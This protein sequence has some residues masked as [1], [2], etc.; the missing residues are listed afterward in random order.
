MGNSLLK[1][2]YQNRSDLL[3]AVQI[4]LDEGHDPSAVTEYSESPLRVASNN[5]RFDVVKLLLSKGADESQLGWTNIFHAIAYGSL[6]NLEEAI[7]GGSDLDARDFWSRTPFLF[8]ILVGDIRKT[9]MLVQAGADTSAVGR[10]GKTPMAYAIKKDN[11]DMLNWLI[12]RGFDIEQVNDFGNAPLMEAVKAGAVEC[13]KA[14][15]NKG[16][17]ISKPNSIPYMPIHEACNLEIVHALLEAGADINDMSK[18]SR[19]EMLGYCVDEAP[20]TSEEEYFKGKHRVFGKSNP[21][22]SKNAFWYAMVK[23]GGSAYHAISKFEKDRNT[24]I[25]EPTLD[26]RNLRQTISSD[27]RSRFMVFKDFKV[28]RVEP[29]WSYDRFGKSITPLKD[30]RFIEI[31]GEHEDSYDPDFCIYND[32]FVHKGNGECEIYTYPR[33][34][35]PPTDFHTAT[36]VGEHIYII[37]NL[38]YGEDRQSGYTPIYQLDINT[39]KM[40]KIDTSGDMPG[41]INRHKAYYDGKSAIS[42]KGGNLI[43]VENGKEDY[44]DNEQEY[45]LCLKSLVWNKK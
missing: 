18:E 5:G 41:W 15:I 20:D 38:G 6:E 22:L 42:I 39:L 37:G 1:T 28:C 44:V 2:I 27:G 36:L 35:F 4:L 30:G 10:C 14:L 8:S 17:D 29:A 45:S 3:S 19:A 43:V 16:A 26:G 33:D 31:A 34:V 11:V 40:K 32:V 13:L 9:E 24:F 23:S 7:T 12:E 21:E 25:D